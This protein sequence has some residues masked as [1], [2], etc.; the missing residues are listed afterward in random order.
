MATGP[1][2][3]VL[4]GRFLLH[5]VVGRGG[6]ATVHLAQDLLRDERVALKVVH[7][8]LAAD[9]GVRRRLRREVEAAALLRGDGV[10]A[11]FDL[12]E[13]DGALALSMPF[14]GGRTLREHVSARGPLPPEELRALGLR[15]ARALADAHGNG[16]LHRDL[17]PA[18]IM[19]DKGGSDAVITDFGLARTMQSAQTRSTGL[20]G[21]VGYA[22]P[23]VYDGERADPRSDL[24]GLGACLYLAATGTSPFPVDHPMGALKAQLT[25]DYVPLSEARPDLPPELSAAVQALLHARPS[26]RPDGAAEVRELLAGRAIPEP[27]APRTS[28]VTR[29]YLPPGQWTVVV[30]DGRND[31]SRR[32]ALRQVRRGRR[33]TEGELHRI[34]QSLVRGLKEAFGVRDEPDAP[35]RQL[36]AA[37]AEEAGVPHPLLPMA[38]PVYD[39]EFRL[40]DRTDAV[41]AQRLASAANAL[42]FRA[43]A[44]DLSLA[45][46]MLDLLQRY[47]WAVLAV[48]WPAWPFLVALVSAV[49]PSLGEFVAIGSMLTMVVLSVLLPIWAS[50][51]KG[52]YVDPTGLPVAYTAELRPLAGKAGVPEPR[53]AVG[54]SRAELEPARAAPKTTTTATEAPPDRMR[55]LHA[56]ALSA[57]DALDAALQQQEAVLPAPALSDLRSTSRELRRASDALTDEGRRL[58]AALDGV[59]LDDTDVGPLQSRRDRLRTLLRAGEP[60]DAAELAHLDRALDAH[61]RDAATMDSLESRFAAVCARLLEVCSTAHQARREVLGTTPEPVSTDE[62][63]QRLQ[64]EV[65]AARRA[66]RDPV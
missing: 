28:A 65:Q 41:T 37:V 9:L 44:Q 18:N 64:R 53:Y 22:A 29:Q 48:G 46:S 60:V 51:R 63:M 30:R 5:G 25:E 1:S 15:L 43:H 21:T 55:S 4:G 57:L 36:V 42:G 12:H 32:K 59:A 33:T 34:G 61:A 6:T 49:L 35:E 40:V 45:R 3:T 39:Q 2:E 7:P 50:A 16:V 23:E 17:T 56:R 66:V 62:A 31:L 52:R 58:Q 10:L 19:L 38:G 54:R 11:P 20:L 13:L 26:D 47:W 27:V 14:H 24:Y 8:H